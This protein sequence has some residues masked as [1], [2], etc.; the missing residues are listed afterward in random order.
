MRTFPPL[1]PA[2]LRR[3][4]GVVG[5]AY[6]SVAEDVLL[7]HGRD[8]TEDLQYRPE[9][10]VR[11]ADTREVSEV[12]ALAHAEGLPVTPRG[13]GSGLSGGALPVF[14]GVVLSLDRMNRILEI[15]EDNLMCVAQPGVITGV[16]QQE[17]EKRGLYYPPDP[18]SRAFCF[19][20]GNIAEN[21]GG[22]HCVKYGL[23]RDY[24]LALEAV[25]ADGRVLRTGGKLR[26]DVAGYD[27]ART[28]VGSEGT[29]AVVTEATLRLV[30]LPTVRR[31]VLAPFASLD[32]AA[33][34][35]VAIYRSRITPSALEIVERAALQAAEEHLMRPVPHSSAE[36]QILVELDGFDE[37]SVDRD[38]ARVGEIL[39]EQGALDAVLADTPAKQS[40]LWTI[41]RCLGEAV[42]KQAA[43]VECDTAVPPSRVPELL[44]GVR[45]V[46]ERF[47]I[48]QI[49]YGHAGDGNIH[50]NVLTHTADHAER[51]RTLRPAIEE[52]FKVA[53]GLGGTIT[54]EH[55]VGC[56][57]SRYLSLCRDEN[58]VA[59]MRAIKDAFDPKGILNPGKVFPEPFPSPR[60]VT[61]PSHGTPASPSPGTR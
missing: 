32:D 47:G 49:S 24:V 16:L 33:R 52:I 17:V 11:P 37:A 26:K 21:A 30:P 1:T 44:R 58:A 39:L 31:L 2:A 60:P 20:G 42:R 19:L 25:L 13:A 43:Y 8:E 61:S 18:A 5:D 15:D 23:T 36:A 59:T 38:L 28:I 50:V 51:E 54:G 55:G 6:A 35:M 53:V 22:P 46:A 56:S 57:Q 48:R 27:L 40:D 9:V 7:A 4:Q 29:L 14:G 34:G 12:L 41:R 3:L 10:V 45:K